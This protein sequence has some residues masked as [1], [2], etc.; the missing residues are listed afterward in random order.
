MGV[1]LLLMVQ[2]QGE[3]IAVHL[4]PGWYLEEQGFEVRAGDQVTVRGSRIVLDEKPAIIATEVRKG[5][6]VL[7][8]RKDNGWPVWADDEGDQ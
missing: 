8:L 4:G 6:R 3:V 1:G 5:D 7:L 2:T